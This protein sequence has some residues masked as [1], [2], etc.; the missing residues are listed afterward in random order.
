MQRRDPPCTELHG[1]YRRPKEL[2]QYAKNPRKT[3]VFERRGQEPNFS[4][5]FKGFRGVREVLIKDWNIAKNP[6]GVRFGRDT[7]LTPDAC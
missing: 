4:M 3:R 1:R 6:T 5:F 7:V 2:A